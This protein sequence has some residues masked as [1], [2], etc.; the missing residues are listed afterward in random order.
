MNNMLSINIIT[1][2]TRFYAIHKMLVNEKKQMYEMLKRIKI[3]N[4]IIRNKDK[5]EQ[6]NK[7]INII[8]INQ[9]NKFDIIN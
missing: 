9:K 7:K 2:M 6:L 3:E 4:E 1:T 8:R 5:L